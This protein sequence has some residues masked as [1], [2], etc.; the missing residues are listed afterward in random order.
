MRISLI[1][2]LLS[3][4]TFIDKKI[5]VIYTSIYNS[6]Y[7]SYERACLSYEMV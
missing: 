7:K 1:K 6:Y 4:F 2:F 5:C 3:C